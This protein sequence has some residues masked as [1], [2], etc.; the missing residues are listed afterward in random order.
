M[1]IERLLIQNI[2][3]IEELSV[4]F[5]PHFNVIAGKNGSGKTT[6]L[7]IL[8]RALSLWTL[9]KPKAVLMR[10]DHRRSLRVGHDG[11]PYMEEH[12]P[13]H[14]EIIGEGP[15]GGR[16]RSLIHGMSNRRDQWLRAVQDRGASPLQLPLLAQ[17][18]PYRAPP[19]QRKPPV[20][21][22]QTPRIRLAGYD[23]AFDLWANSKKVELW[24]KTFE[25]ATLQEGKPIAAFEAARGAIASCL[26][27]CIDVR[28]Y[29]KTNQVMI[30]RTDGR[31]EPFEQLSD[32]YRTIA[33]LVGELAWRAVTLNPM[34]DLGAPEKT[35]GVV[36]I[37]E[38]DLH[39]HPTWQQGIAAQLGKAFPNVQFITTTHSPFIIQ[40]MRRDQVINLDRSARM[41]YFRE[42]IEDIAIEAMGVGPEG[43]VPR[44]KLYRD[45]AQAAEEYYALLEQFDEAH[46]RVSA[47][48]ARLDELEELFT[49]D[50]GIAAM[51]KSRRSAKEAAAK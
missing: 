1:R 50:P 28:Y 43:T 41:E 23:D 10:K 38:L 39:L 48:R 32:G 35:K 6:I 46:P 22:V 27:D 40:S 45:L 9:N 19:R 25:L 44:S 11:I 29:A 36:L 14:L 31:L 30:K 34:G 49:D 20:S 51:L 13:H 2:R 12:G 26:L 15:D 47:L 4:E 21:E 5:S 37:D 24:L 42:G 16:G 3:A 8:A 17:F 33:T 18:S 7:E